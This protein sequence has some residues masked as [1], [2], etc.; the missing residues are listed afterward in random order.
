MERKVILL[1]FFFLSMNTVFASTISGNVYDA[2][3]QKVNNAIIEIREPLQRDVIEEGYYSFEVKKGDYIITVSYF[4]G[5]NY[6]KVTENVSVDVDDSNQ[7]LDLFL[8]FDLSEEENIVDDE[9]DL[10]ND[11]Q[12]VTSVIESDDSFVGFKLIFRLMILFVLIPL[13]SFFI[14]MYLKKKETKKD[15]ISNKNDGLRNQIVVLL[16]KNQGRMTQKEIRKEMPYSEAKISLVITEL[17]SEGF[18]ERIK[19]GRSNIVKLK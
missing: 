11:S 1:I 14:V 17:E 13:I 7:V 18:L 3:F 19:K 5:E 4:D 10:I 8:F 2:S 6:Q 15:I 9:V 12:N 16:K